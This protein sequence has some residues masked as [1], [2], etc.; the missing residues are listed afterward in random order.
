MQGGSDADGTEERR[1]R[2]DEMKNTVLTQVLTQS[3]R[4]R[5]K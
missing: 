4:A 3:A 2:E 5:R 1:K